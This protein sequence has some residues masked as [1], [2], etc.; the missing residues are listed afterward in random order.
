MQIS[1]KVLRVLQAEDISPNELYR[2]LDEL[3]FTSIRGCN[4]RYFQWLFRIDGNQ[5]QDMQRLDLVEIGRGENR[6]LEDHESCNGEG[7]RDCGWIGQISR[8]VKDTTAAAM[9]WGRLTNS[10]A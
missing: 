10:R 5:L 8:A 6:M 3:A 4:R 7:C 2:M 1:T 9:H